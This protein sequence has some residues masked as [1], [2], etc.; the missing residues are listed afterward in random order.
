MELKQEKLEEMMQAFN[1]LT[2]IKIVVF[3]INYVEIFSYPQGHCAFCA[4]M[5]NNLQT[6]A[7]CK[8][9]N[10]SSFKHCRKSG[11]LIIYH[12]HA[13]L[14]E[15]TAPI[16]NNGIV[17]GYIMFGQISDCDDPERLCRTLRAICQQYNVYNASYEQCFHQIIFKTEQQIQAAAT[18]LEACTLYMVY[19][20]LVSQENERFI[21]QLNRYI[22]KNIQE[23]MSIDDLCKEFAISR[24][25]LYNLSAQ[26]LGMS[27]AE[28][29]RQSRIQK[30]KEYLQ[31]T[32][33]S[34]EEI[35][36]KVGFSDYNYFCRAFK[37]RAGVPAKQYRRQHRT[38]KQA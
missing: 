22:Q 1:T 24:S 5:Q 7:Y 29:I 32:D 33:L 17:I 6:Q 36:E 25:K 10:I 18:I 38:E 35:S 3:D 26:Y 14:V 28:Y 31:T 8:Q 16:K 19:K 11:E 15:A 9:S 30:A 37:K 2:G 4:R 13:G 27:I 21:N 20:E 23:F 34:V 12:C